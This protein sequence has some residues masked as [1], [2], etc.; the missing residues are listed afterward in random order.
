[1]NMNNEPIVISNLVS[2]VI[3]AL[4]AACLVYLT[5]SDWKSAGI[6]FLT[7][8]AGVVG[9]SAVSR[10]NVVSPETFRQETGKSIEQIS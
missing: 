3:A 10:S 9:A 2:Q 7:A 5:N 6:A 8:I 4:I 1:M